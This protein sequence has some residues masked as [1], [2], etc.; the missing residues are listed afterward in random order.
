VEGPGLTICEVEAE[1]ASV[2]VLGAWME[3]DTKDVDEPAADL[4]V[5]V[6]LLMAGEDRGDVG[7]CR[8]AGRER[9]QR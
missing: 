7:S 6:R 8:R 3:E 1:A 4:A 5:V 9:P 2:E